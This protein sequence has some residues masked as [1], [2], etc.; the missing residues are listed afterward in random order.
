MDDRTL[1]ALLDAVREACSPTT[2]SQGVQLWRSQA[3]SGQSETDTE[4]KIRVAVAGGLRSP[5]VTLWPEDEDWWC[6]CTSQGEACVHAAA[7]VIALRQAQQ[8]GK[9][10]FTD[11]RATGKLGYRF[12]RTAAG[13]SFHRVVVTAGREERIDSTLSAVADGR[14]AGPRFSAGQADIEVEAALGSR[15]SGVL[16]R[17]VWPELLEAMRGCEDIRLDGKPVT[18]AAP[19]SPIHGRLEACAGGFRL[20]LEQDPAITEIFANGVVCCSESI[21]ALGESNLDARE[22][23]ELRPG[24]VYRHD[25]LAE[26]LTEI[27]PA[28]QERIP[29]RMPAGDLPPVV[30][31]IYPRLVL[32][33]RREG[34]ELSVLPTIVYGDP[35]VARLDGDALTHLGGPV[36]VRRREAESRLARLL[37]S[38]LGMAHGVRVRRSGEAAVELAARLREV[39]ARDVSVRGNGHK[40]FFLAP[41]LHPRVKVADGVFDVAFESIDE[42]SGAVRGMAAASAVVG[43]WRRG[44]ALVPLLDGGM[45]P[46]PSDFL[47]RFGQRIADLLAARDEAGGEMPGCVIPDLAALCDELNQPRPPSFD[48]LRVLVDGFDRLPAAPLP[49]DLAAPLRDYQ[50]EGVDWLTFLRDAGLGAV[51]ADDMGLGKTI[52]ALCAIRGRTLVVAPTSVMHNWMT[53]IRKFRPSLRAMAYHGPGRALEG[54]ADVTITT[55]AILRLDADVLAQ[56]RWDTVVL[57]E[58][59]AIKNPDSQVAQAA[60]R[61]RAGFR[62]TLTGTPVENRLEEL[63]SQ[64]H[65]TN[66]GLLGGRRDFQ[67]RVSR[68]VLEGVPGAAA[69]LRARIRPFVLRRK[70][71]DVAR[72]LPARTEVVL[73]CTLS[74][75]ERG[76]YDAIRAAMVPQVLERLRAG[77]GVMAALEALLRLRQACCHTGLVPGQTAQSSA[78]VDVLM[79]ELDEAVSSGHKA[80]VFSQWTSLLDLVEPHLREAGIAFGRLDGSTRDRAAVVGDFQRQDGPPVLLVSLKAGGTGLNLTEADHVYL[81]DPWWNPAVEDQAADRAHRIGQDK[82]VLIHKLVAEATI[83]ERIVE[84]Q[85]AKRALS[86]AALGEADA[87][88]GLTRE[89]LVDVLGWV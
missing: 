42:A 15:L 45:A 78:K 58:A 89:D 44:E 65:F 46:I 54:Q 73:R 5:L 7:A 39:A 4:I 35:P 79:D 9:S 43:A 70:K 51:L 50:R 71:T 63:W 34:D 29:V 33:S 1:K 24:R 30:S 10:L 37:E 31:D 12:T 25:Q 40:A 19:G 75:E 18:I 68:P 6:D 49:G 23:E 41:A 77:G 21:R 53:E 20:T 3:V 52:Q 38:R 83:E 64:L 87:A 60:Y 36:P 59:Q 69:R 88:T 80:L 61:L 27:I 28:L 11:T 22:L 48:R 66:R 32:D 85:E 62:M 55:Y 16:P 72:E 47:A 56:Q 81:M 17:T 26:L 13:L 14:V 2:W 67:E 57:D 76:T 86:E 74:E 8:S 84:L 82:P